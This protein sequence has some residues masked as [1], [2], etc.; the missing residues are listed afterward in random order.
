M[1]LAA[2]H[3]YATQLVLWA[4][5]VIVSRDSALAMTPQP[6]GVAVTS[7][8]KVTLDLIPWLEGKSLFVW[9]TKHYRLLSLVFLINKNFG[10]FQV[11]TSKKMFFG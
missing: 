1:P 6:L 3:A 9:M 11:I 5:S 7:V 4:T 10:N 2:C 8:K